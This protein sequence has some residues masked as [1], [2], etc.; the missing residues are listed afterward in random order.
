MNGGNMGNP[1][2]MDPGDM[3]PG[4]IDPGDMGSGDMGPGGMG[5][6]GMPGDSGVD[7]GMSGGM[8]G[9]G[10][11]TQ[12][13]N[14]MLPSG[15]TPGWVMGNPD[16]LGMPSMGSGSM[17]SSMMSG[18]M[19]MMMNGMMGSSKMVNPNN[20]FH[21]APAPLTVAEATDILTAYLAD[22]ADNNLDVRDLM[23]FDN[24]AYAQIIELDS[25]MG[26]MEVLIDPKTKAVF[27][28]MGPNMM[29]NLKYGMMSGFGSY[30]MMGMMMGGSNAM[31]AS[32]GMN[33]GPDLAVETAQ[34]YL[35]THFSEAGLTADEHA[36]P[37]YGYYTLHVKHEDKVVGMLSVNG[38][39][40]Q[41]CAHTWHGEL[42][43]MI[44][45]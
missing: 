36:D 18:M 2:D 43:E 9:M 29:W 6:G 20:P 15:F 19:G 37:F 23:I 10:G 26:V 38:F 5:P 31:P 13:S 41:V 16:A 45:E 7:S 17:M 28:E 44:E 12:N 34:S 4:G 3:D 8:C 14:G 27:P 22:M 25:G 42:L 32:G 1:G 21:V 33:V 40:G 30:G 39:S 35:D 24:H 11:N